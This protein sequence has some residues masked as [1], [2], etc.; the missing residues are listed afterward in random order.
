[1]RPFHPPLWVDRLF[2]NKIPER[3]QKTLSRAKEMKRHTPQLR[4]QRI[5]AQT[6]EITH[7]QLMQPHFCSLCFALWHTR[8]S[9]LDKED[10]KNASLSF[11]PWHS[12]DFLLFTSVVS[13]LLPHL[14]S[15]KNRLSINPFLQHQ[16][17]K[18][19]VSSSKMH[20]SACIN[21]DHYSFTAALLCYYFTF[22]F[23]DVL[24]VCIHH[25]CVCICVYH[26]RVSSSALSAQTCI[27][28][29]KC[30]CFSRQ[31]HRI[32]SCCSCCYATT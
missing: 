4:S 6:D 32:W 2:L 21:C 27:S 23:T 22:W 18:H 30:I 31:C 5:G 1:M 26:L 11:S 25:V 17:R 29:F 15:H 12:P 10:A 13:F 20:F 19:T 3:A 28:A 8:M 24:S 14:Q 7:M 9:Q 16:M